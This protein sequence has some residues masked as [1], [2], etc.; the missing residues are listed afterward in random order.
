MTEREA[1]TELQHA[2]LE[3]VPALSAALVRIR[4][5]IAGLERQTAAPE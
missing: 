1:Q 4:D 3:R 2:E 5:T